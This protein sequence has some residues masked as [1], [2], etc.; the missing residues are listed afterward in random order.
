MSA[1][2]L[3]EALEPGYYGDDSARYT[4]PYKVSNGPMRHGTLTVF[5]RDA[6]DALAR[7]HAAYAAGFSATERKRFNATMAWG[8][9]VLARDYMGGL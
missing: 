6:D 4:V 8:R 2:K 7:A 3:R 5:A 1:T 9:P